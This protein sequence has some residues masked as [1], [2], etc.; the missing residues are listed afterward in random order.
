MSDV[1]RLMISFECVV[2]PF[3]ILHVAHIEIMFTQKA[4][5]HKTNVTMVSGFDKISADL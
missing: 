4:K 2:N 3:G 1:A 5:K